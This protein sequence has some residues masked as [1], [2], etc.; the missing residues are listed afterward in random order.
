MYNRVY[1]LFS[2]EHVMDIDVI[3]NDLSSVTVRLDKIQ[4]GIKAN[5]NS[6]EELL[7]K[8]QELTKQLSKSEDEIALLKKRVQYSYIGVGVSLVLILCELA[9]V[10]FGI[11]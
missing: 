1:E 8:N 5:S 6:I 3:W 10:L 4:N 2:H 11:I 7:Q 9:A